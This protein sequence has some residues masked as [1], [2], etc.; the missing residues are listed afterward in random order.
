MS[1]PIKAEN[2]QL[3]WYYFNDLMLEYKMRPQMRYVSS[4]RVMQRMVR[5][6]LKLQKAECTSF[7]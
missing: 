1:G 3:R 5:K 7:D 2:G 6:A 4:R